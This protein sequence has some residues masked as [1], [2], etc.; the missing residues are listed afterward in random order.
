[1]PGGLTWSPPCHLMDKEVCVINGAGP[2]AWGL[3][4]SQ[5]GSSAESVAR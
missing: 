2:G 1:M 5:P 3:G 4:R